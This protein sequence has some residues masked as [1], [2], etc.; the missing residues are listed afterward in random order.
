[1]IF[2]IY[3]ICMETLKEYIAKHRKIDEKS[4]DFITYLSELIKKSKFK[5]DSELYNKALV[6]KQLFSSIMSGKSKPGLLT[7]LKFVFALELNN[8]ECKYL[9]K[10]AGFTLASHSNFALIIRYCLENKIYD[11]YDVNK[12][13]IENGEEPIFS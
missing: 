6:S 7:T 3:N 12:L 10:K 11:F 2:Y 9:L 13:L 5:K 8:H 4:E 1:M